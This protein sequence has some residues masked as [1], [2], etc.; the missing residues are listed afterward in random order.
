MLPGQAPQPP[1]PMQ[2]QLHGATGAF[3]A[4]AQHAQPLPSSSG[5]GEYTR[6]FG[7]PGAAAMPGPAAS[8]PPPPPVQYP[9]VP[10]A[11]PMAQAPQ[12]PAMQP[13]Q[14]PMQA[15]AP[16]APKSSNLPLII[17]IVVMCL[18]LLGLILFLVLR[19]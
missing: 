7:A 4:P 3:S 18:A 19:K 14:M 16:A 1:Q 9:G 5:P 2:Q 13:S 11:P 8:P 17:F 6:L 10:T 15:P 12:A